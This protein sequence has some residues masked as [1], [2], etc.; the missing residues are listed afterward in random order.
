[1]NARLTLL[2][3]AGFCE[4]AA[5]SSSSSRPGALGNCVAGPD[6]SCSPYGGSSGGGGSGPTDGGGSTPDSGGV[7]SD[8]GSC[9]TA[10]QLLNTLNL[11]C[12][13]CVAASCCQADLQCTGQC[14]SLV[15]CSGGINT[16]EA[17]YPAGIT[18]YN[19]LADCLTQSCPTQCPTLPKATAGDF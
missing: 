15:Q 19:D 13:P 2:A 5:C 3:I 4:L 9:G 10:G 12:Q 18:A 17:Q 14:L 11:Q 1:M 7:A 6:A 16:C 8:S